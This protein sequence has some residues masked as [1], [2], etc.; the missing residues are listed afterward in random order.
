MSEISSLVK[1][2]KKKKKKNDEDGFRIGCRNVTKC[3][4]EIVE[5]ITRKYCNPHGLNFAVNLLKA[6]FTYCSVAKGQDRERHTNEFTTQGPSLLLSSI[7]LT[8]PHPSPK[9]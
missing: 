4:G 8:L 9:H 2:K 1:K 7:L 6:I 5:W 3:I